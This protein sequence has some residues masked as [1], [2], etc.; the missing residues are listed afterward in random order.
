MKTMTHALLCVCLAAAAG[1][2]SA[3]GA[4]GN[5]VPQAKSKPPTVEECNARAPKA[6]GVKKTAAEKRMDRACVRV[7][8][9]AE[10]KK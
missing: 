6:D 4:I 1:A 7:L 2:V 5:G 9:K 8:K 3:Q 10:A